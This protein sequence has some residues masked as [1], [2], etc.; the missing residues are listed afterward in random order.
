MKTAVI[1]LA[2]V[3]TVLAC[4]C[5]ANQPGAQ[6]AAAAG[7]AVPNI[8][9]TWTGT[10]AGHIEQIGFVQHDTLK[11]VITDQ[12][13]RAFTGIKEY[14]LEDGKVVNES[15]SGIITRNGEIYIVDHESGI[16]N[17]GLIGQDEMEF[18]YLDDMIQSKALVITL[19]RQ[20]S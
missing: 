12:K 15:F 11:Y 13:G 10:S 2:V 8:T 18:A 4:G 3:L 16:M 17:G 7:A 6:P 5:V 19:T 9:G 1:V 14:P 20:K